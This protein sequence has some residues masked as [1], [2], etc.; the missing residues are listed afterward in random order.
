[1]PARGALFERRWAIALLDQGLPEILRGDEPSGVI[2]EPPDRNFYW[3]DPF[4]LGQRQDCWLFVEEFDRWRGL[5][6]IAALRVV[7]GRVISRKA[8]FVDSHHVSF[9]QA[10]PYEG[11]WIATVQSCNPQARIYR[12]SRPGE[13]WE[14]TPWVLPEPLLDPAL[15]RIEDQTW[16][17]TGIRPVPDGQDVVI[18]Y[19]SA[20]QQPAGWVLLEQLHEGTCA[21]GGGSLDVLRGLRA[22]QERTPVY[23]SA[24]VLSN[25]PG[26][27][28]VRRIEGR[29][30]SADGSAWTGCHTCAWTEDGSTVVMDLWARRLQPLSALHRFL[31]FRADP[32]RVGVA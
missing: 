18:H 4:P 22:A 30:W 26:G 3:A 15:C 20:G 7:E 16:R 29:D 17:L 27:G 23:G 13:S 1:M 21:R 8:V 19:A 2:F 25:W 24:I 6:H 12:F 5:G 9:P 31:E 14:P 32:C 11:E 28:V 10:H